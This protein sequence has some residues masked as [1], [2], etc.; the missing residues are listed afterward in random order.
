MFIQNSASL[1]DTRIFLL[2]RFSSSMQP[3]KCFVQHEFAVKT[4]V[5]ICNLVE[6]KAKMFAKHTA[7]H[8]YQCIACVYLFFCSWSNWLKKRIKLPAFPADGSKNSVTCVILHISHTYWF[9]HLTSAVFCTLPG[10][11]WTFWI[12]L[13]PK[14]TQN[15]RKILKKLKQNSEKTQKPATPVELSCC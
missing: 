14:K 10:F 8:C 5:R 4:D 13:K 6:N 3:F 11:F 9:G 15:S 12:K 2:L 7:V 1:T